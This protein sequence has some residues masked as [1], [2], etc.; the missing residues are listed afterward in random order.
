MKL[1]RLAAAPLL[2]LLALAALLCASPLF[3]QD[4]PDTP[5][6]PEADHELV[7]T[8]MG[9]TKDGRP[10]AEGDFILTFNADGSGSLIENGRDAHPF[11]YTYDTQTHHCIIYIGKEEAF[12]IDVAFDGDTATFTP[13]EEDEVVVARRV[14]DDDDDDDEDDD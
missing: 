2:T 12:P 11:A 14:T 9:L 5:Q 8:W 7:G 1:R 6:A 3:A 10:V 4:A 13:T